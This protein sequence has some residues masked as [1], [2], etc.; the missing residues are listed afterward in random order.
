MDGVN[1]I[2]NISRLMD[3]LFKHMFLTLG[4][5]ITRGHC[6]DPNIRSTE[7]YDK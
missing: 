7:S 2:Q 1:P 3:V 4:V 6:F 5:L